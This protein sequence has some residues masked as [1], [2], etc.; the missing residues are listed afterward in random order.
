MLTIGH[1]LNGE[2]KVGKRAHIVGNIVDIP[3]RIL[4]QKQGDGC[5]FVDFRTSVVPD[6]RQ[7]RLLSALL[8]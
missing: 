4:V 2:P 6:V 5:V 3:V 7:R 8:P 1:N